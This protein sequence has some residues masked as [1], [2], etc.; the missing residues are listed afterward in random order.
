MMDVVVELAM[1]TIDGEVALCHTH[2]PVLT[3]PS[4]CSK[5]SSEEQEGRK[6]RK[7]EDHGVE[8]G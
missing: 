6:G 1:R 4:Y 5:W 8:G 2:L 7:E 3:A